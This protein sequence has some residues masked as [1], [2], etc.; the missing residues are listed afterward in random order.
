ML[1]NNSIIDG[2]YNICDDNEYPIREVVMII[3]KLLKFEEN[4]II[5]N[6]YYSDG[7][8]KK[9][10]SNKKFRNLFPDYEFTELFDG[11]NETI[12]WFLNN[13]ERIRE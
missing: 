13:L 9:T 4:S 11:L 2:L 3:A 12:C 5:F 6:D 8:L 10:V 1:Y 7:I